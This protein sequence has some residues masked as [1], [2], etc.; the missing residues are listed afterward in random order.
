[1]TKI[2]ENI[3]KT[4]ELLKDL[5]TND[6]DKAVIDKIAEVS[7]SLDD[8]QSESDKIFNDYNEIKDSYINVIKKVSLGNKADDDVTPN[9]ISLEDMLIN[10]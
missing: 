2:N 9:N 6:T 10:K 1:M 5:I 4:R 3:N 8:V 7:K